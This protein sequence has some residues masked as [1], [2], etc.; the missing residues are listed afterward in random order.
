MSTEGSRFVWLFVLFDL[1][2]TTEGQRRRATQF[3]NFLIKD[4]YIRF[5]WSVYARICNGH[6]GYKTHINRLEKSL[7]PEGNVK[8]LQITDKQYGQMLL[9]VKPRKE[10]EPPEHLGPHDQLLLF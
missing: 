8:A 9:L 4:G 1:P 3:R 5:Q 6:D 10:K 7:P 2:V